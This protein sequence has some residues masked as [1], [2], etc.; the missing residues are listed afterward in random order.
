MSQIVSRVVEGKN[1]NSFESFPPSFS[2]T[3]LLPGAL[4]ENNRVKSFAC[5]FIPVAVTD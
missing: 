2:A 5:G 4:G 3:G 1:E